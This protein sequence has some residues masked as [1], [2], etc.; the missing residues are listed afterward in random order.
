MSSLSSLYRD[1]RRYQDLLSDIQRFSM[2]ISQAAEA[3][4]PAVSKLVHAMKLMRLLQMRIKYLL[5]EIDYL[6]IRII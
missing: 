6:I 3:L 1:L 4:D 5:V 2:T